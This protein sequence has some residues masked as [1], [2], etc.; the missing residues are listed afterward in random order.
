M[1]EI[2]WIRKL[3]AYKFR[4]LRKIGSTG[5]H[6]TGESFRE[7]FIKARLKRLNTSFYIMQVLRKL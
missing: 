7:D 6:M 4:V 3:F 2:E 5:I 1:G